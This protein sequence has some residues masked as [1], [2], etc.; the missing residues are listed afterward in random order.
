MQNEIAHGRKI[1]GPFEGVTNP[2]RE[3]TTYDDRPKSFCT[4]QCDKMK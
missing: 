2:P 3:I 4:A 1:A